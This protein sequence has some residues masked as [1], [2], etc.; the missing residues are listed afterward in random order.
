MKKNYV[1]PEITVIQLE[2]LCGGGMTTASVF[3]GSIDKGECISNF[4]VLN[5]DRTKND[6]E[7]K[8]LWGESNSD[9]WGD[10]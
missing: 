6:T 1:T 3:K 9:K 4:E 10:D 7:Y 2:A 8:N 5:E